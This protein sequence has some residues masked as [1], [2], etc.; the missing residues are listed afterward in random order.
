[1]AAT[2]RSK[3]A[4]AKK[5]APEKFVTEERFASLE[6]SVN[7]LVDIVLAQAEAAKNT[8]AV[9][10]VVVETP[11]EKEIRKA[12]PN[13]QPINPE[14]DEMCREIIGE[15]FERAAVRH[16]KGG[17]MMIDIF[18]KPEHSNAPAD[19]LQMYKVDMRSK[20]V[21]AEGITGV[22]AFAKLVKQNLSRGK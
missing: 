18:I 13:H 9:A 21:G 10:P 11:L 5:A 12:G 2:N 19:Y 16:L 1:M 15:P 22:E 6:N 3:A 20:E 4:A 8:P 14:W 17:G 7:K